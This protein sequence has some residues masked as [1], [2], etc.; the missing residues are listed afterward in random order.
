M[1]RIATNAGDIRAN[2]EAFAVQLHITAFRA[3]LLDGVARRALGLVA[4]EQDV[5]P[6]VVQHGLEVID[7]APAGAHAVARNDDCR[8]CSLGQVVEHG[9]VVGVAVDLDQVI[10]CQRIATG[11]DAF[12]C[13]VIPEGLQ[14]AVSLSEAGSQGR[15]QDDRELGPVGRY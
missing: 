11:L 7:D 1:R 5:M 14:A 2:V 8:A 9:Y 10:E 13:L 3:V 15:I 12:A 6:G 4:D